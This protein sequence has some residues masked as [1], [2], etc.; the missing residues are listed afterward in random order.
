MLLTALSAVQDSLFVLEVVAD[1]AGSYRKG[2]RRQ[3]FC[4]PT[5]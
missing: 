2:W 4:V 3:E 1:E 5:P